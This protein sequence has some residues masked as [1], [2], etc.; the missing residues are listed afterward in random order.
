MLAQLSAL[1]ILGL[2][3]L[4][5]LCFAWLGVRMLFGRAPSERTTGTVIRY[6]FTGAVALAATGSLA[7][8]LSRQ[9]RV[10][11][12]LGEWILTSDYDFHFVLQLDALSIP[13]LLLATCLCGVVAAFSE[14]YLHRDP[15]FHR[16]FLL[17]TLFALGDALTVL[18]GS[19]E[20]LYSSWELLGLTSALLIGFFHTRIGPVQSGLYTFAVYRISDLGLLIAAVSVYH[21]FYNGD[22][23]TFLGEGPWPHQHSTLSRSGADLVGTFFFIAALGKAGQVPFSGWLPRAM[24]G[25][26]PSTAIFY[27]A[28]SV[29]AGAYLLLRISPI[30]DKAPIIAGLVFLF[31]LT[32]AIYARFVGSIVTDIK[33]SLA[34][35]S[36][37]QVG[38]ILAEIGLGLRILPVL[39]CLGHALLR[40]VQF[41]RAPSLLHEIHELHSAIGPHA[42]GAHRPHPSQGPPLRGAAGGVS[43]AKEAWWVY[44]A[45]LERGFLD[46]AVERGFVLPFLGFCRLL[47]RLDQA[48]LS[49]LAGPPSSK[50]PR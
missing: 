2:V 14:R 21:L 29:H 15:G 35:A 48:V 8:I 11:V 5:G 22:F 13:F 10:V 23:A 18:A 6:V 31:G 37:A 27:G 26:T 25:P 45:A 50:G 43:Q 32:T 19:I 46:N 17:L 28:L 7:M 30:L 41:L 34:Y 12:P 24:E 1:C 3:G 39:H 40:S 47:H 42:P 49:A 36:L 38:L 33:T 44:R 9:P 4:E 16:Y 20:V